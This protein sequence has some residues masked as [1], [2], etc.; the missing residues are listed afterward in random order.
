MVALLEVVGIAVVFI[1]VEAVLL[2]V[3]GVAVDVGVVAGDEE[4]EAGTQLQS[5][6]ALA[7]QPAGVAHAQSAATAF[8]L[9]SLGLAEADAVLGALGVEAQIGANELSATTEVAAHLELQVAQLE[10]LVV[11]P[12]AVVGKGESG[13][14]RVVAA[15]RVVLQLDVGTVG[16]PELRHVEQVVDQIGTGGYQVTA[17][18]THRLLGGHGVDHYQH[19]LRLLDL[20]VRDGGQSGHRVDRGDDWFG[21]GFLAACKQQNNPR[22]T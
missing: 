11:L 20:Y 2:A 22:L 5:Q 18:I 1:I 13:V 3:E 4:P 21:L 15:Q 14:H 16:P 6:A 7:V 10:E 9:P 12:V 8:A 19:R 17:H